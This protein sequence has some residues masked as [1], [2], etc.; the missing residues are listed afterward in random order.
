MARAVKFILTMAVAAFM[1][2]G[3]WLTLRKDPV[4][5]G[6]VPLNMSASHSLSE[7]QIK[8]YNEKHPDTWLRLTP[9]A[10]SVMEILTQTA[11]GVRRSQVSGCFSLQ[12]LICSSESEWDALIFNGTVP[13]G[14]GSLRSVSHKPPSIN[15][16][17]AIVKMNFTAR[18]IKL[19]PD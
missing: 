12:S 16:A 5:E 19:C 18:A 13:S 3:L 14:T 9:G 8:L 2:G 11:A 1:L 17:T 7:E 10:G 6:T 15:A 4:P